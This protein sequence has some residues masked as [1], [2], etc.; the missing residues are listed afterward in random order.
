MSQIIVDPEVTR[1]V[2]TQIRQSAE[3]ILAI[4]NKVD[5]SQVSQV[6]DMQGGNL[7]KSLVASWDE[8]KQQCDNIIRQSS[9][10]SSEQMSKTA[11]SVENL[12]NQGIS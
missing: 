6:R 5:S 8:I 1:Y 3:E 11:D 10:T 4:L 7:Y 12:F 2:G 9:D